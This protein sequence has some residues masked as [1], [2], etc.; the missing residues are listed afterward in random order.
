MQ[1]KPENPNAEKAQSEL[2][3][4]LR[5]FPGS[6]TAKIKLQLD[7]GTEVLRQPM[8]QLLRQLPGSSFSL[9]QDWKKSYYLI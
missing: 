9:I 7:P 4:A 6:A 3:I 5:P 8:Q 1:E 2:E